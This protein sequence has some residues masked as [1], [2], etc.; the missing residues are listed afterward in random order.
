MKKAPESTFEKLMK[1]KKF[2]Y[3]F[4]YEYSKFSIY[5]SMFGFMLKLIDW[6]LGIIEKLRSK[7]K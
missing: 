4:K 2:K 7:L 3:R 1:D 5:D 6:Y